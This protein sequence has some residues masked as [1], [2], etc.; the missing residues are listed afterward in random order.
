[1]SAESR[2]DDLYIFIPVM[3]Q[4]IRIAE[5]SGD[6]LSKDDM[7]LGYVDYVYFTQYSL[8]GNLEEVDGGMIM[9]DKLFREKYKCTSECISDVLDMAYG[10]KL[11]DFKILV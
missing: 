11:I 3:K 7:E 10:N 1:M 4:I 9:L 8:E 2:Y 5:G 6:N